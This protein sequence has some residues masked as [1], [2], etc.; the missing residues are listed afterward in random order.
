[1][2]NLEQLE[3]PD[4]RL[5]ASL[6]QQT[7]ESPLAPLSPSRCSGNGEFPSSA[8]THSMPASA[9]LECV[10]PYANIAVGVSLEPTNSA[11]RR[12]RSFGTAI[13]D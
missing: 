4:L 10:A 3:A 13:A 5:F 12:T 2:Q 7:P 1:M 11:D 9:T 8:P 6:L